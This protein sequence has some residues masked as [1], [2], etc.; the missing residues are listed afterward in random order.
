M[1][2]HILLPTDDALRRPS[3]TGRRVQAGGRHS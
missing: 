1:F 2:T 3:S